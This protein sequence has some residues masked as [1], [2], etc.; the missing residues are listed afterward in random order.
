MKSTALVVRRRELPAIPEWEREAYYSRESIE[1]SGKVICF[2]FAPLIWL[3]LAVL[4]VGGW[5]TR[6]RS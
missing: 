6:S 3:G 1:T 5:L 4:A 2:L